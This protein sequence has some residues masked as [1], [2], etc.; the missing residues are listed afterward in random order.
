MR[1]FSKLL[2]LIL[3]ILYVPHQLFGQVGIGTQ[4]PDPSA[5]MHI[6]SNEQGLLTPRMT[7]AQRL[8][9]NSPANGLLVFDTDLNTFE[10]YNEFQTSWNKISSLDRDNY[11]LVKSQ[12]D[13]PPASG[14]TIIL[15]E[16]T[17]YEIN[18]TVALSNSINLNGAYISGLDA[19]EDVLAFPGGTIF[20]GNTGG[21]I[22]NVT[23]TGAKAFEI[24]GS[25]SGSFLLQ[26][27]VIANMTTSVGTLSGL[28]LIFTNVVQYLGNA[29]GITYSNIG[30]LL[31]NNQAWFSNN[32]GTFEKLT[33][34]FG[35]VEKVSGFSTVDGSAIGF[36]VSSNPSVGNGV[37]LGTV[38]SGAST[39]Y[40]KR[41][42]LGSYPGYNFKNDW[43]V[44][45]PGIPVES[46]NNATANLYYTGSNVI[47]LGSNAI[48]LPVTTAGIRNFRTNTA[49]TNR[50][51]YEGAKPRSLNVYGAV[52]F[53]AI[54]G[55]RMTFSIYKNGVLVPGTEVVYDISDTNAR[56]GLS[57]VGTVL[58]NPSDFV[59]I[60]VER[61]TGSLPNQF[62]VTSYNLLV[63]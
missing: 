53:T 50:V 62:L 14:G 13:F 27:T 33:G 11:V 55:M 38:F 59:E 15:D 1:F 4:S 48:K 63:N 40:V 18:G 12:A 52:S 46:D 42:T 21:S 3:L 16:N 30:N 26:N 51:V 31:L 25:G 32:S 28:G 39:S 22:R 56:Q 8:A 7:T 10:Y 57:I 49:T 9:I 43:T 34:T 44:N 60:Y 41:Y 24:T 20:K 58:V 61:T 19:A 17:Y 5:L 2:P 47:T 29:N 37:I 6:N 35:L 23:L 54:A 36:D 45:C